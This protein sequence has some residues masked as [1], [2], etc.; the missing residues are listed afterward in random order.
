M[1]QRLGC[2][3]L[4]MIEVLRIGQI[5]RLNRCH[6]VSHFG[7]RWVSGNNLLKLTQSLPHG[8]LIIKGEP[9]IWNFLTL[10]RTT[11]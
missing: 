5:V 4:W 8:Y 2:V 11:S 10:P 1:N 6:F 3:A 9:W 7:N